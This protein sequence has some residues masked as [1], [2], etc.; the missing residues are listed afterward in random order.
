MRSRAAAGMW[1][2]HRRWGV[3]KRVDPDVVPVAMKQTL[4]GITADSVKSIILVS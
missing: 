2:M 1:P 3:G 4:V